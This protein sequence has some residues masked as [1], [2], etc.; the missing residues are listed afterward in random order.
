MKKHLLIYFVGI[1]A[2]FTG[3][4][5]QIADQVFSEWIGP[6]EA[7]RAVSGFIRFFRAADRFF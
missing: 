1:V 4:I 7:E 5:V 6:R 3:Y 2:G